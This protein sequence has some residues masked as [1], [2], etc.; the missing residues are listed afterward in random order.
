MEDIQDEEILDNILNA[1]DMKNISE[2][3]KICPELQK[4]YEIMNYENT[5][6]K[7]YEMN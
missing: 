2:L 3:Y 6:E 1:M 7:N 4:H 5:V